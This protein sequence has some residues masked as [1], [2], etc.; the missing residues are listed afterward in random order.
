MHAEIVQ[1]VGASVQVPEV[2]PSSE[3]GLRGSESLH[4]FNLGNNVL[5]ALAKPFAGSW[6]AQAI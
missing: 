1:L 6:A 5:D 3:S 4:C 2:L